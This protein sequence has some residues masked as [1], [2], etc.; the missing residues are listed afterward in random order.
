MLKRA[1]L[2]YGIA[3]LVAL[4]WAFTV[5]MSVVRRVETPPLINSALLAVV[6]A[7]FG[8]GKADDF[9]K[10]GKDKN[11]PSKPPDC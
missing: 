2:Y 11:D 3:A 4:V 6:S 1:H 8:R 7:L 9:L 5:V 10:E